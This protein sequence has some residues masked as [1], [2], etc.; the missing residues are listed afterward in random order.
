MNAMIQLY[1]GY[2]ETL[3][4]QAMGFSM[5]RWDEQLLKYGT[6][7]EDRLMS[8]ELHLPLEEALDEGWRIL[9]ECFEPPQ[10]GLPSA[11]IER[12][13]PTDGVTTGDV[14]ATA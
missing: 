13:W 5:S 11:L 14:E 9:A 7:F 2:R 4:K 8:L 1:A 3:E 12:F 6:A 10:T